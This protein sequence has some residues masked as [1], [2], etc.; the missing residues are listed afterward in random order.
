MNKLRVIV[1]M[2]GKSPEHDVS[3]VSGREVVLHLDK[4]KYQVLPVIISADG[5][6]WQ[7]KSIREI[8]RL[9]P[10]GVGNKERKDIIK[11]KKALSLASQSLPVQLKSGERTVVFIAMHGPFGEDGT[12]QALLELVGLPYTGAKVLAS[13][14]GMNKIMFR[15]IME[16]EKIP[17]PVSLV[18]SRKDKK[19]KI[20]ERFK[21]PLV[22]KPPDQGSSVGVTIVHNR[23]ELNPALEKAFFY[24]DSLLVEEYLPGTEVACGVLGNSKP[25]ALPVVEIVPKKEFFDYEAKYQKGMSEEIVPARICDRLTEEVQRLSVA[26]FKAIDCR[27]FARVDLIISKGKPRVLEI[28]TIPG[29]TPMSLLPKEAASAGIPY[30]KLLDTLIELALEK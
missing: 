15:K 24:S 11:A 3:L 2:G 16:R 17:V 10:G 28:N 26:V 4:R 19:S 30:S 25:L 20:L 8:L 29:L 14:L 18:Y 9:S 5:S 23:R 6:K 13:A 22:V 1:L 12:I 7:L 27:G 21:F